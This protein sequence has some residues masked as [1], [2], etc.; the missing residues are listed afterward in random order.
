MDG[1]EDCE[2]HQLGW[3]LQHWLT[4]IPQNKKEF[5]KK[6]EGDREEAGYTSL[7]AGL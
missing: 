5:S 4:D 3:F 2:E 7:R 6:E 1:W